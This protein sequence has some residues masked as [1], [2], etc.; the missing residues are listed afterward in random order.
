MADRIRIA[1]IAGVFAVLA[2]ARVSGAA[3]TYFEG[4]DLRAEWEELAQD[5][6]T[7]GFTGFAAGH[8]ITDEYEDSHGVRFLDS[9]NQVLVG[10]VI[11]PIDGSG[12][13]A[14]ISGDIAEFELSTP[15]RAIAFLHPGT[16][17]V[18]IYS[19]EEQLGFASFSSVGVDLFGG[20]ISD[21][22]FD[23]V[24]LSGGGG[25][26]AVDDILIG[27]VP[28][29]GGLAVPILAALMGGPRRRRV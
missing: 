21:V 2:G 20:I 6:A 9:T 22:P 23:R 4:Q 18:T 14:G 19:G 13:A 11:F 29:P 16:V 10:D 24:T 3:V 1:L 5:W 15:S 12:L 8:H 7:I 28:G 26:A 27:V 17:F 25:V